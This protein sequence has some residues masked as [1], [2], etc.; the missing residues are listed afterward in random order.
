MNAAAL[1]EVASCLI[2]Q[3]DG[4]A[5]VMAPLYDGPALDQRDGHAMVECTHYGMGHM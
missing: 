3:R 5:M 4:Q 2:D 1:C